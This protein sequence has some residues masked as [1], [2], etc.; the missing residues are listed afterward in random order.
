M[1]TAPCSTHTALCRART[2]PCRSSLG[3]VSLRAVSLLAGRRV[4]AHWAVSQ[5]RV[6]AHWAVSQRRVALCYAVSRHKR[7]P[8]PS[9]YKNCI[10][11]PLWPSRAHV[12]PLAPTR[13]LGRVSRAAAL[14]RARYYTV[15]CARC[16][17][18][19]TQA[20]QCRALARLCPACR[21]TILLYHDL[22]P[23]MG[24]SPFQL[25]STFFFSLFN[26]L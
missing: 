15:S 24:N 4:A 10:T 21:D 7:P 22:T 23:K 2:A 1:H 9:R 11:T 20:R 14:C 5:R 19:S 17:H 6:I 25:P 18:P 16:Y 26:L 3:T 8:P 13:R 12:L